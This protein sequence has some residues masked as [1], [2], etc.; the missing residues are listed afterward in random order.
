MER[1][2]DVLN[3]VMAEH[4]PYIALDVETR[5][6]YAPEFSSFAEFYKELTNTHG[7]TRG[8]AVAIP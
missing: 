1:N 7:Q 4:K 5:N 2:I 8:V 6:R 3:K